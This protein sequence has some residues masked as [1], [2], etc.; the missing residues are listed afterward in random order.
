MRPIL[1]L[2][3]LLAALAACQSDGP[4][5]EVT[6]SEVS[7][8]LIRLDSFPSAYVPARA[9]H[10]YLPAAY[11][12]GDT[13]NHYPVLYMHDGQNLFDTTTAYGGR[14]WRVDEVLERLLANDSARAAIVVGI[15]NIGERRF[16]EYMPQAPFNI[17]PD[18]MQYRF[19]E[20]AGNPALSDGYLRFL[21][22][23]LKPHIDSLFPTLSGPDDTFIAGSSMGGLISLYAISR[24]PRVF[25]GAACLSTHWPVELGEPN[26]MFGD[27]LVAYFAEHLPDPADHRLYFDYGTETLDRYYEPFQ[28]K[29]DEALRAAG[30]QE[31]RNWVTRKFPGHEHSETFWAQRLHEPLHFLLK[32]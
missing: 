6:N 4:R 21:T 11:Q 32:K 28:K 12:A 29:M 2:L 16:A 24:H 22:Q 1:V 8:E 20:A 23:E 26:P 9:V 10:V 25:G 17:Y 30:Y 13:T 7:G 18:S 27:T 15:W 31:G 14:E 19:I 5:T 3:V